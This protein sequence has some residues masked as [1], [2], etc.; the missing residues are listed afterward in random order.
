MAEGFFFD[1]AGVLCEGDLVVPGAV[2]AVSRLHARD[3]LA[4]PDELHP[5]TKAEM[6][7]PQI[8]R[9]AVILRAREPDKPLS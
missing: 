5:E 7:A 3:I 6:F 1:I 4:L 8:G 2:E 9:T